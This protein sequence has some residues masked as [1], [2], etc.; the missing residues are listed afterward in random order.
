MAAAKKALARNLKRVGHLDLPGGGQVVVQDGFAY[1]GHMKP[2]FGT[3]IVDVRDPKNPRVTAQIMLADNF[4]HTHK[5]RVAGDLMVTNVEQNRRHFLRKGQR[6]PELRAVLTAELG[7][8]P[9]D[10]EVAAQLGVEPAQ[11]AE[12]DAARARGYDE[13]GFKVWDI[14]DKARPREL[15]HRRTFGFGS[16][17]F[18]MDADY[19]YISTE[20]EGYLG[21]IL[22]IYDLKD[23]A[24]PQ[25]VSRWHM[26]GQHIAAGEKPTWQGYKNRLHHALR[27]GDEM[28]ASVWH[29]GFRVLDVSDITRPRTVASHDYHPP[30]PEPTHTILPVAGTVAG[31]RIAVAVDEEH[32]HVAG[33][34]HAFLWVFDVTDFDNITALSAFD[35]SELDSPWARSPG[36]FGAHQFREKLDEPLVYATWFAGGLRVIDV[37]DPFAPRETAHFIPEPRAKEPSPQ[38]N[39]VDVDEHGLIYLIDRNCG[40]DILEMTGR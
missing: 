13:G 18:D 8:P 17:R 37:S 23:P 27:V 22:V 25:E 9:E 19:A 31:R 40:F 35:V 5:V 4:S 26:P 2:P 32:D 11:V 38:S 7:R 36:R 21:N 3:S 10:A 34:L 29:A 20:M 6:L 16:H 12:L 30:F 39:D 28:W 1:I 14:S 33:R 24:D 15:V